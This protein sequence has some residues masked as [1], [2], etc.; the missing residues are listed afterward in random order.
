MTGKPLDGRPLH[1]K[2]CAGSNARSRASTT[3]RSQARSL[4][5]LRQMD[6]TPTSRGSSPIARAHSREPPGSHPEA[7]CDESMGVL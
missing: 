5:F 4:T 6:P 1:S 2:W 3:V 7:L